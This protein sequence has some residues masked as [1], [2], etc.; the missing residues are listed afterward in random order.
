MLIIN[1][2]EKRKIVKS[3]NKNVK[4]KNKNENKPKS[5]VTQHFSY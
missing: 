3:K 2:N 4:S 1:K 5:K